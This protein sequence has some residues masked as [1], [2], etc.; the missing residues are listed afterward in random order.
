MFIAIA[1]TYQIAINAA[2]TTATGARSAIHGWRRGGRELRR[3]GSPPM[4][5]ALLVIGVSGAQAH[6]H[7]LG[8]LEEF[9]RLANFERAVAREVARN[10]VDDAARP[11]RHYHDPGRQE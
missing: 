7:A 1:A 9:R 2:I 10:D 4:G 5:N 3:A 8:D 6:A 11:R